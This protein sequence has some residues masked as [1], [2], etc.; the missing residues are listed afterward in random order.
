MIIV[1]KFLTLDTVA[2]IHARDADIIAFFF[3]RGLEVIRR[4]LCLYAVSK[5]TPLR[6][7]GRHSLAVN[8]NAESLHG[9]ADNVKRKIPGSVAEFLENAASLV[10]SE[11]ACAGKSLPLE[12]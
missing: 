3:Q 1:A 2:P 9:V 11:I 4:C 12:V 8:V 10:E 5:K 7:P 6:N